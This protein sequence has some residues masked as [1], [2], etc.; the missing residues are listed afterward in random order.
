MS[1]KKWTIKEKNFLVEHRLDYSLAEM[2]ARIGHPKS[3]VLDKIHDLGYTWRHK[4]IEHRKLWTPTEDQFLKDNY[5]KIPTREIARKLDRTLYSVR[6]RIGVLSLWRRTKEEISRAPEFQLT[7][8]E[9]AYIAGI[10]DGEGCFSV[11]LFWGRNRVPFAGTSL[12]ISNTDLRLIEW[13][14]NKLKANQEYSYRDRKQ[15]SKRAYSL[16]I[17]QR[18]HLKEIIRVIQPYL[19]VKEQ[20]AILF[21]RILELKRKGALNPELLQAILKFKE[22]QDVRN[23]KQKVSTQK[24]RKFIMGL[25]DI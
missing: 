24:L 21:L 10:I 1:G 11:H 14:K 22:L 15:G 13:I 16:A 20:L 4:K 6:N 2:A 19:I 23:R 12:G 7:D 3:S 9:A 5:G 18:N 8:A 25:G 17:N